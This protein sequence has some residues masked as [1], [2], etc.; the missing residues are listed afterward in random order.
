MSLLKLLFGGSK[1]IKL[2]KEESIQNLNS[3][4]KSLTVCLE[5]KS[6]ENIIARVCV[7][8]DSSGSMI[9]LYRNGTVQSVIEK[10]LP[11][12]LRFD[13]DGELE[14]WM[15]STKQ[16]RMDPIT[17]FDFY[18]YVQREILDKRD[19]VG[20]GTKYAPVMEDVIRKYIKEEPSNIPTFVIFITDGDN[21]DHKETE[22]LIKDAVKHNIFWQFVGIG[23]RKF[24]FLKKLDTMD[25]R[26]IDNANFFEIKN[27]NS[28]SD[29]ELYDLLLNEYPSW[30]KEAKYKGIIR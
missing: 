8:M 9:G 20:G 6:I 7:V 21:F 15:F 30:E 2:T 14:M 17:E 18:G 19:S 1:K 23:N 11:L 4:K 22:L 24:K 29:E 28:I 27:I 26:I 13:D 10:L 25:G 3:R 12:S 16:K 5:K